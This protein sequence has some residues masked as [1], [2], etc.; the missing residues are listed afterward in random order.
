MGKKRCRILFVLFSFL[1]LLFV[2]SWRFVTLNK[3]YPNPKVITYKQGQAIQGGDIEIT[4]IDSEFT[5]M[6]AMQEIIP[7][8]ENQVVDEKG[9][10][11]QNEH[12][13][14]LLVDLE[15]HNLS[16]DKQST[17]LARFTAQSKAW[18]NGM[19]LNTYCALNNIQGVGINLA[20]GEK[21]HMTMPFYLYDLQFKEGGFQKAEDRKFHLVLS[22]YPVKN[23]VELVR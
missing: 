19:D 12:I 6:D 16:N 15:L 10:L 23:M 4:V 18:S 1:L 2:M 3:E 21:R 17:S 11:L 13:K 5:T 7:E 20:P 14:I 9:N 8:I 22:V